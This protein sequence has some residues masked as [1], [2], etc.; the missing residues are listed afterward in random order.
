MNKTALRVVMLQNHENYKDLAGVL[1]ISPSTLSDKINERT[2]SGFT[3][4]EI[5][6]IK[7]HYR[8]SAEQVDLIFFGSEVS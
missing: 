2:G 4:P 1:N 8:L 7:E 5:V 3:Q 6:A